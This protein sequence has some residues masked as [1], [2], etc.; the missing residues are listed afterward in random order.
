MRSSILLALALI[1]PLAT[2]AWGAGEGEHAAKKPDPGT[3]VEMPFL[4][5]PMSQDG[6]LLGYS[7]ISSKL[8]CTSQNA[9]ITVREK[10]AFIQD[11]NVRDV[12][13]RPVGLSTDPKSVDKDQLNQ[14]L[15]ANA[16][17][18]VG[19]KN[20]VTMI[21]AEI[22]YAPLH[23]DDTTNGN[24]PPPEQAPAKAGEGATASKTAP[25]DT[26]VH[27]EGAQ[28]SSPK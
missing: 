11:A 20:V 14:R 3:T 2:P 26:A 28:K 5:A 21:F 4:I 13:L 12:N 22:K 25:K 15:T 10:I 27:S 7:Y 17:R 23:A 24:V 1:M 8:V 6:K 19:D 9:C 16:K 18:I